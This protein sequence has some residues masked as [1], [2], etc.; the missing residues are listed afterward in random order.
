MI[1]A[2]DYFRDSVDHYGFAPSEDELA[3][4]A[5][6]LDRVNRALADF[7]DDSG[8]PAPGFTSGHRVRAKTEALIAA[9]YRAAVGG[10]HEKCN[11]ID[12]RDEYALV[13]QWFDDARLERY[14]LAREH[15]DS[16]PGWCH[17][18]RVLPASGR[19]TFYP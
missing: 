4:V 15:P 16:T 9:G 5:D 3:R 17:L 8:L 1:T 6:L 7:S 13:D 12:I 11:A 10:E 14:G 18:Q 2:D 19:R